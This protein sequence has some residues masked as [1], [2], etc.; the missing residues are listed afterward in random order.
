[1]SLSK[2]KITEAQVKKSITD[3]LSLQ[4]KMGRCYYIRNNSVCGKILR[5]NGSIGWV[6]NDKTGSP[7]IIMLTTE[8][9]VGIECKSSVGRQSPEQK[10]AQIQIESL[11]GRYILARGIEDIAFLFE[12]ITKEE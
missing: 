3:Y 6:K 11:N 10:E 12:R 5:P 8:G 9:F 4:E 7:D 2:I 1:M